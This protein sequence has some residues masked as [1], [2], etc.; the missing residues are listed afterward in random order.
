MELNN[1]TKKSFTSGC[2]D[3]FLDIVKYILQMSFNIDFFD[4]IF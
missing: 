3:F 2:I 1:S 4:Q